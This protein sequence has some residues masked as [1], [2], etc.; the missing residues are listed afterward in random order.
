MVDFTSVD[1]VHEAAYDGD[2][3]IMQLQVR[4]GANKEGANA[5]KAAMKHI[6]KK[7]AKSKKATKNPAL[8]KHNLSMAQHAL[9][10]AKTPGQIAA[11][12]L[13]LKK[14]LKDAGMKD[15]R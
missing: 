9:N 15:T 4:D 13:R 10:K 11:A 6:Q 5:A 8:I 12:K 3:L 7:I 1:V 14:A 2:D